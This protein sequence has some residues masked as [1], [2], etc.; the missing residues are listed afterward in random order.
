MK[1]NEKFRIVEE[2]RFLENGEMSQISG[3]SCAD[4]TS[5]VMECG[6]TG[7]GY[8]M[9]SPEPTYSSTGC[10]NNYVLNCGD[11]GPDDFWVCGAGSEYYFEILPPPIKGL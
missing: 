8:W 5:L 10:T 2:S 4:G 6:P 1:P 3:G 9:C 7:K 11:L